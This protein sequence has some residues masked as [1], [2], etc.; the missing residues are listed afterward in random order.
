MQ[1]LYLGRFCVL[2]K[3]IGYMILTGVR[4]E[5]ASLRRRAGPVSFRNVVFSK[6]A[7]WASR[8]KRRTTASKLWVTR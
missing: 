5:P 8:R 7:R 3:E 6:V 2:E 4:L 1:R